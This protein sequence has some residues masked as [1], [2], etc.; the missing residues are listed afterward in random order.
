MTNQDNVDLAK[1][2][3]KGLCGTCQWAE[4]VRS[5]KGS[6]FVLCKQPK[7]PKYQGQP[8]LRCDYFEARG[9]RVT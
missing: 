3:R 7:L 5:S 1:A 4:L 2:T 8:V 9:S 6:L